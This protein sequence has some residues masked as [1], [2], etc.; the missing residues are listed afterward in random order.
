M[1]FN[2]FAEYV[3]ENIM[4]YL[5]PY[6]MKNIVLNRILKVEKCENE[7]Q[8]EIRVFPV[9]GISINVPLGS[10]YDEHM[11]GTDM[12]DILFNI[13]NE[14]MD[15]IIVFLVWYKGVVLEMRK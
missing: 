6:N 4:S 11:K 1:E 10:F 7:Y 5:T 8:I 9:E 13:C 2:E 14:I 3:K 12:E 15:I